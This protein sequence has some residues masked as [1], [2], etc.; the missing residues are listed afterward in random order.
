M[1][2]RTTKRTKCSGLGKKHADDPQGRKVKKL[3]TQ[4]VKLTL[5]VLFLRPATWHWMMVKVPEYWDKAVQMGKAI[6]VWFFEY[7]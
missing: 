4:G 2:Q 6:I 1:Q 5:R 3:M 7:F